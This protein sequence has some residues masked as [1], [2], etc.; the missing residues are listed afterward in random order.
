MTEAEW[1]TSEG[2]DLLLDFL[3]GRG[4]ERKLVL[5]A[6]ACCRHAWQAL[7]AAEERAGSVVELAERYA[8]GRAILPEVWA[9]LS[10]PRKGR[11]GRPCRES[12]DAMGAVHGLGA[13]SAWCAAMQVSAGARALV[14]LDVVGTEQ[15]AQA[16]LVRDIFGNPFRLSPAVEAAWLTWHDGLIPELTAALY[17]GRRL[18]EGT[19][20][21]QRLAVLADAL[22]DGGC[23]NADILGHLHGPGP[24]VRGCWVVDLVLAK[25]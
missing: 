10:A 19:F 22:E 5:F 24:H 25:E 1:L 16:A 13:E 7:Q 8:D 12:L 20:D 17:E 11:R 6:V 2:S 21:P 18:P 4:S 15:S 14:S 9:A 3:R 23:T